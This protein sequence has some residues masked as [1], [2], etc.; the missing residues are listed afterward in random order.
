[1]PGSE[2]ER[3]A[4]IYHDARERIADLMTDADPA[5]WRADVPACPGWTVRDVVSHLVAVA[6]DWVAGSLAGA[7]TDAQTAEHIRRFDDEDESALLGL[8][9]AA[10][11]GLT[12]RARAD[13][14]EPPLGDITCHEHDIRSA[15]GRPGARDAE[16]V[17]WTAH[18]LLSALHTPVPLRVEVEDGQYRAGPAGDAQ[19]LLRTTCFEATRWRTGRRSPAQLAAMDWTGDPAPVLDH[20]CLFGP[21][22]VD[23]IE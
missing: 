23:V 18:R 9:R 4:S 3:A 14:L 6:Q 20:L 22:T 10:A 19:L 15:L 21:A 13:G 16:S 11:Q 17:R 8:W 7:P 2:A 12:E 1:M 5:A